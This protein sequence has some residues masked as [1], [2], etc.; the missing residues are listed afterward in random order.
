LPTRAS[1]VRLSLIN[2]TVV[3]S[4]FLGR[5]KGRPVKLER[6][7][8]SGG[9]PQLLPGSGAKGSANQRLSARKLPI[10]K[11]PA[12][13]VM[14]NKIPLRLPISRVA[15]VGFRRFAQRRYFGVRA[16]NFSHAPGLRDAA[17]MSVRL[18]GIE[19]FSDGSHGIFRKPAIKRTQ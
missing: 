10:P 15:H 1:P 8:I 2:S 9:A 3:N 12:S 11:S 7:D 18:L 13:D 17:T 4:S 6:V 14:C 5:S 19:N 16:Q